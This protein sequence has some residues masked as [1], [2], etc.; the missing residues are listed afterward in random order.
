MLHSDDADINKVIREIINL[1]SKAVRIKQNVT[2]RAETIINHT[3]A[4]VKENEKNELEQAHQVADQN[5]QLQINSAK[6]ERETIVNEMKEEIKRIHESY[7][8]KKDEK[9]V[10]VLEKLFNISLSSEHNS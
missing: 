2:A 9:A 3:K 4:Q 10:E 6:E 8:E 7:D 1:D 5:Y